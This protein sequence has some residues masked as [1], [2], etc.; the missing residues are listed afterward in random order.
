MNSMSFM[1]GMGAG[2]VVGACVGMTLCADKKVCK[3]KLGKT[4]KNIGEV[5]ENIT[6][7]LGL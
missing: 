1:K 5:I 7:S 3:K 6:D 4:V 2:L